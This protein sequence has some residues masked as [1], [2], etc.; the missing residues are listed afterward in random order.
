[1]TSQRLTEG[2][3]AWNNNCL[4]WLLTLYPPCV[5]SPARK[6]TREA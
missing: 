5:A 1:M 6:L 3:G 4:V 2:D